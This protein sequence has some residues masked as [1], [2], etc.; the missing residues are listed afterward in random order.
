MKK[1]VWLLAALV[2]VFAPKM[3]SAALPEVGWNP[4]NVAKCVQVGKDISII[5]LSDGVSDTL[6]TACRDAG[7]GLKDYT[8]TC[9]S[10]T[11]YRV[12][13]KPCSSTSKPAVMPTCSDTDGGYDIYT[14]GILNAFTPTY[15]NVVVEEYCVDSNRV[16]DENG[17]YLEELVC[18]NNDPTYA[19]EH[20]LTKCAY[21]CGNGA[22]K[23]APVQVN[24]CSDTDSGLNYNAFGSASGKDEVSQI[25]GSYQD[26]CGNY[27]GDQGQASGSYIA[28]KHCSG[29]ASNPYVHTQWYKCDYGCSAGACL[30][31]PVPTPAATC[32]ESDN[33]N[34]YVYGT[35]SGNDEVT[36]V[37]GTYGDTCG[38]FIGDKNK[39]SGDYIAETHCSSGNGKNYVHTQWYKCENG[40]AY[41]ACQAK[42]AETVFNY[43]LSSKTVITSPLNNSVFT[44]FPR[45]ANINWQ[46]VKNVSNYM[47]EVGCDHC[48]VGADWS[49]TFKWKTFSNSFTTQPLA[50]DNQFRARVLPVFPNGSTGQWS[51]YTY[52]KFNTANFS[53]TTTANSGTSLPACSDITG[54]NVTF[55]VCTAYAVDHYWSG[56]KVKVVDHDGE[57]ASV[58]LTNLSEDDADLVINE[59]ETFYVTN[60]PGKYVVVTYLGVGAEGRAL[61]KVDSNT[62]ML[63]ATGDSC[64]NEQG[65]NGIYTI[66]K[67][68][69]FTF[70]GG[71]TFKFQVVKFNNTYVWLK[72]NG[73]KSTN[74]VLKRNVKKKYA[75]KQAGSSVELTYQGNSGKGGA[76]V[77]VNL[78]TP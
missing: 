70:D 55:I 4:V 48:G 54:G 50:G 53:V 49:D 73:T 3:S 77:K 19:Y 44:N 39:T 46:E 56:T 13:W 74:I 26:S 14:K 9:L 34:N 27:V 21:G 7:N 41:G 51:D 31:K 17:G 38:A 2:I 65:Q 71:A 69:W 12:D 33:F 57:T 5:R 6:T 62:T 43:D 29:T 58:L 24:F 1:S 47:V 40:C 45:I 20:K 15:G 52:F 16:R 37:Y 42:K 75:L 10:D 78:I 23:S 61:F 64:T 8:M 32:S 18:L 76:K 22:C 36:G 68:N 11:Q 35:T 67:N 30:A 63:D 59:P 25:V 28:E 66:C 72:L 60:K